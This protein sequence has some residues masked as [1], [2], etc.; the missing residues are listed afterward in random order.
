MQLS[1]SHFIQEDLSAGIGSVWVI[2]DSQ[3]ICLPVLRQIKSRTI[4]TNAESFTETEIALMLREKLM[5]YNDE[6]A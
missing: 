1:L 6:I 4:T 5:C 2:G 3:D